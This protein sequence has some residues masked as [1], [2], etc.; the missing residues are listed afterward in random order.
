MN[1]KRAMFLAELCNIDANMNAVFVVVVALVLTGT[2][3][4]ANAQC[5]Y[6]HSDG[7]LCPVLLLV[8]MCTNRGITLVILYIK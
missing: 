5:T 7:T 1:V 8:K 6:L 4:S 2:I 3:D